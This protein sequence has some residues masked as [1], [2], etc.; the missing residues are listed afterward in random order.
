LKVPGFGLPLSRL[1]VSSERFPVLVGDEDLDWKANT[2]LIREACMLELMETL[3]NKPEWW[4]K[5]FDSKITTKWKT[6]ALGMD[7]GQYLEH[8][9]FTPN[10]V[11]LVSIYS[12]HPAYW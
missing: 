1:P 3:T 9:D 2:L 6:E 10:M 12:N 5:V 7:W 4:V 11:D 8:A